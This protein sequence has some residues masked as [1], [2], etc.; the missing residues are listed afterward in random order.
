MPNA[1]P[2]QTVRHALLAKKKIPDGLTTLDGVCS[3]GAQSPEVQASVAGQHALAD[4]KGAVATARTSLN[5][6][7]SLAQALMT[8]IKTL[9]SDYKAVAVALRTYEAVVASFAGG[10]GAIINRA[11]LLSR[12]AHTAPSSLGMVTGIQT[13]PGNRATEAILF[14]PRAPGATTYAIEASFTAPGTPVSWTAL[15]AGSSRRRV[16]KG[17]AAGAQ[18]VVRIAAVGSDGTQ[19]DWSDQVLA[20]AL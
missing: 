15:A 12:D 6:R 8:A 2:K 5:N 10:N 9:K 20:T 18:F 14:W 7:V 19:S 13:K 1:T 11:G 4:L 3:A 16:V 17:P